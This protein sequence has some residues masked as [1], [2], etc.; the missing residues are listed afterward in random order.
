MLR[1]RPVSRS[2][3]RGQDMHVSASPALAVQH[4]RPCV[5]VELQSRPGRLLK[6]IQN[7]ADL[8]VGRLVLR[9]PRN[10]A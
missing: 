8:F 2:Q 6:V 10:H 3:P 9:R 4:G 7:R 1:L 5:A